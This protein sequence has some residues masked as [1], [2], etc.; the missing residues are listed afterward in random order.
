[1]KFNDIEEL[2][3][4]LWERDVEDTTF[5]V[6]PDYIFAIIGISIDDRVVYS[7]ERMVEFLVNN[8]G[9]AY[10]D[11]ER[12]IENNTICMIPDMGKNSPIIVKEE[13]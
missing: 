6:D 3:E 11:A 4:V 10:E 13:I 8:D 12:F 7:Y 1:M 5:F 2:K 9:I